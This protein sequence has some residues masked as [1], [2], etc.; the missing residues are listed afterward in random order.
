MSMMFMS[1]TP[2]QEFHVGLSLGIAS[3]N[4]LW[5]AHYIIEYIGMA[6]ELTPTTGKTEDTISSRRLS[7]SWV[8]RHKEHIAAYGEGN[9]RRLTGRHETLDINNFKWVDRNDV[10]AYLYIKS[11][12]SIVEC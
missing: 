4:E 3:V 5:A 7:N 1:F 2:L 11:L 12:H 6:L 10:G 8:L 9:E